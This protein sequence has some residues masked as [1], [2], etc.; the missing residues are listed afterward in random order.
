MTSSLEFF[1]PFSSVMVVLGGSCS[2]VVSVTNVW[3]GVDSGSSVDDFLLPT[4]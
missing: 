4:L 2:S 3:F 1:G